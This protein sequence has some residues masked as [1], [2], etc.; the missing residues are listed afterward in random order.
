MLL[1]AL[2]FLLLLL[3]CVMHELESLAV[4]SLDNVHML[5]AA[6]HGI[7]ITVT[8][9]KLTPVNG[10][11]L[12]QALEKVLMEPAFHVSISVSPSQQLQS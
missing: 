5:Q 12:Q 11:P 8:P 10:K 3:W 7:G 1:A 6:Y 2:A 9:D 4:V